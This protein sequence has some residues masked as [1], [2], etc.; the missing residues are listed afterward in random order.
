MSHTLRLTTVVAIGSSV[1]VGL[2]VYLFLGPIYSDAG[3]QTPSAYTLIIFFLLPLILTL[4]ERS[5]V[6]PGRGGIFNLSRSAGSLPLAFITGW[7]L[8][9]GLFGLAALFAWEGGL[10]LSH[11][12]SLFFTIQ[13]DG[14]WLSVLL[15][16]LILLR[17][18]SHA[19]GIWKRRTTFVYAAIILL[20][21]ILF[22]AW[23]APVEIPST[24]IYIPTSTLLS[25]APYLA[26]GLWGLHL[27][28]DRRDELR[29]PRKRMLPALLLPVVI[30]GLAGAAAAATLLVYPSIT[31]LEP[32]PLVSLAQQIHPLL[33]VLI[34]LTMFL[35][36]IIGTNE[37]LSSLMKLSS[38]LG[39][40]G[41]LPD[42]LQLR[43]LKWQRPFY[44]RLSF[45][46]FTPLLLL[47]VP[48]EILVVQSA[49]PIVLAT[50]L[51]NVQDLFRSQ[52]KLA[53]DRWPKLP[54]HPLVP[55]LAVALGITI[56][57]GQDIDFLPS[58]M[59]WIALGVL[60]YIFYARQGAIT[61][62]QRDVLVA[63]AVLPAKKT[64]FR[65]MAAISDPTKAASL[66]RLGAQIAATHNGLLAILQVTPLANDEATNQQRATTAWHKL[67]DLI[68]P[69]DEIQ[70][71]VTPLVRLAPDAT[72]GILT[73]I[74]EEK[75]DIVLLG[76]PAERGAEVS[77]RDGAIGQIV[78]NA[79]CEVVV[80]HGDWLGAV[81]RVL[82]PVVSAGHSPAALSLAKDLSSAQDEG[83]KIVALR[84][85]TGK[86][87]DEKRQ[88]AERQL[89]KT[90]SDLGD[91][92]GI[93]GE[94]IGAK[95]I[96]EG[97][98]KEASSYD[99]LLL[100]LSEEGFLAATDFSGLPVD[101]ALDVAPP[102]IL[103]KR[104]EKTFRY[105]LRRSWDELSAV[106]PKLSP[107]R[108]A[109]VGSE[110]HADAKADIDFYVLMVLAASIALFGL[111]QNSAAVII[112]A[113][114]V[115][116][117]MSPILAMAYSIV[118]GQAKMLRQ[119]T[120]S[121]VN[122]IILAIAVAALLSLL[123][124]ALGIPIPP[125]NEILA[126]TQPNFLD[127]LVALASGAAAAYAISRSEVSA[128]LPGVAIAA[129]LVPPLA[130][131]GYGLGTAQFD[132]AAGSLLLFLTNL[133]AIILAAATVF[134]LLGFR[135]PARD[136]RDEQARF[137]LKM[138]IV[139]MVLI[140]IPLFATTRASAN[141]AARD[142]TV[143]LILEN[144]WPPNQAE[145]IDIVV[146]EE[147]YADLSVTCTIFDYAGVVTDQ[148]VAELQVEISNA[149]DEP[150]ILSART[151]NAKATNYNDA[152][153]ARLLTNTPT[154]TETATTES[155]PATKPP[156][157][158]T[159]HPTAID[160]P[161]PT[162]TMQPVT[163]ITP[164]PVITATLPLEISQTPEFSLTETLPPTLVET[165][166][167]VVTP[168]ITSP[169]PITAEP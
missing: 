105:W 163:S 79:Q 166:Q 45:V 110:M 19:K 119:A 26:V 34:L 127:L 40:D 169:S 145:V 140:A 149:L 49:I 151:I 167:P 52:S 134:L 64:S 143:S 21:L 17:F 160:L 114:L 43:R 161:Q 36:S 37:S 162:N 7:S 58:F 81:K 60:L 122:G 103:V 4:A 137:G 153:A 23:L 94:V 99:A 22:A 128:A 116:P 13:L 72:H 1:T 71:P 132:F 39:N 80:L 32:L 130:V 3:T 97:I 124:V 55:V 152:S 31:Y 84:V 2:S 126:R 147:R 65:V 14:R 66:I 159:P 25:T 38:A 113:M 82:V 102:T 51:V 85:L 68:P 75:I 96:K 28:L 42:Q 135:P 146:I 77:E 24:W 133:A 131:V 16:L 155:A 44:T 12:L 150:V 74:W 157:E 115:A 142:H 46:I 5:S 83:G 9:G 35:F 129:A 69:Q 59:P 158:N 138:A 15:V 121:A 6:T 168:T 104:Q 120:E 89:Y 57:L 90:R 41:F 144:N 107:R 88:Q 63:G 47:F 139:A 100:G 108:Q 86:L 48:S 164:L 93:E 109:V 95:N 98:L 70:V 87:T 154:P 148:A 156:P 54:F 29:Q 62:R 73:T 118:R 91:P 30:G 20:F 53:H 78:R 10:V 123:L 61:V 67:N 50:I 11:L 112:G 18:Q 165:T 56:I 8:L 106:L 76:W 136:D 125:T 111:L 92:S 101:I 27:V 33:A 141:Q 117:L